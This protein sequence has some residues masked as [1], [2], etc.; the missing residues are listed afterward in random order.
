MILVSFGTSTIL[1]PRCCSSIASRALRLSLSSSS[2]STFSL[3]RL[4]SKSASQIWDSS[5]LIFFLLNILL[6]IVPSAYQV[7]RRSFYIYSFYLYVSPLPS[8]HR[9]CPRKRVH[10]S[11]GIDIFPLESCRCLS[12]LLSRTF[13]SAQAVLSPVWLLWICS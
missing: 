7:A 10:R 1:T 8:P 12:G 6:L 5:C 9:R 3:S 2:H 4:I 11:P 13:C